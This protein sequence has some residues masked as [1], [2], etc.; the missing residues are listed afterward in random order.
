MTNSLLLGRGR[1]IARAKNLSRHDQIKH[2][3][4]QLTQQPA[5]APT[6]ASDSRRL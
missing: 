3:N 4:P 6:D 5:A 2:V 1:L